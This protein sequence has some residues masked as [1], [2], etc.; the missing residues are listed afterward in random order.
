[1]RH[2]T[3]TG[4]GIISDVHGD[5]AA[6]QDALAR[7]S[8]LDVAQVVCAGDLLDWGPAPVRCI[9]V[10]QERR[11]PC[12]RG[13]HDFVDIG[14]GTLDPPTFLSGKALAFLDAMAPCRRRPASVEI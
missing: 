11:I 12:V 14:G 5:L 2:K 3:Q 10:L 13:N 9:E 4:V 1:M 8:R 7:L 6:L